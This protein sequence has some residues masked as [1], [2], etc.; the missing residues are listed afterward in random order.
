MRATVHNF[1]GGGF[2]VSTRTTWCELA[3]QTTGNMTNV[4]DG[5]RVRVF[6]AFTPDGRM[7]EGTV[8][9]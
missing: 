5:V 7:R 4:G 9:V 3:N 6:A 8:R 2:E 1:N